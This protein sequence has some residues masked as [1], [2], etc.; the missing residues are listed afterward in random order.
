[1]EAKMDNAVRHMVTLMKLVLNDTSDK[2]AK[3]SWS[4]QTRRMLRLL[5]RH[6][7]AA[8]VPEQGG[9]LIWTATEKFFS[10]AGRL[11][12][13]AQPHPVPV[14]F[15]DSYS[16]IFARHIDRL[17]NLVEIDF[18]LELQAEEVDGEESNEHRTSQNESGRHERIVDDI[19]V[20]ERARRPEPIRSGLHV[21][22]KRSD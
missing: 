14:P 1:M 4:D 17:I 22:S 16:A 6:G 8:P 5:K 2:F 7:L 13:L 3:Y 15:D 9:E 12:R 11:T 18:E 20:I 19:M 10:L 21:V